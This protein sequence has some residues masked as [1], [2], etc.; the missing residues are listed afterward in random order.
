MTRTVAR[1]LHMMPIGQPV[2]GYRRQGDEASF[3]GATVVRM[4][5]FTGVHP[6][7]ATLLFA[8]DL[9]HST[10]SVRRGEL[11]RVN[12]GVYARRDEWARLAPWE[13]YAERVRAHVMWHPDDTLCLE[14]AAALSGLP[15]I[16]GDHDIHVLASHSASARRAVGV[17]VHVGDPADR[18]MIELDGVRLTSVADTCIDIA[19]AR[20]EAV[21]LAVADAT[22]RREP[23]LRSVDLV[24]MNED[25]ASSRGRRRARWGLQRANG[26]AESALESLS[27]ACIE[28]QGFPAPELQ[29]WFGASEDTG[30]RVDHWWPSQS[31]A[32]E[33]DGHLKYDGRFGDPLTALRAQE[34]RD[35]RLRD[36]G[37]RT[38]VHW[39]WTDVVDTHALR[40]ILHGAGL[41]IVTTPDEGRLA[42]MRRLLRSSSRETA[43]T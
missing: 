16:G 43:S 18:R 19:R 24:A 12:R 7:A 35:R 37:A 21:A 41:P 34:Q 6:P 38:V 14:S 11:L 27:R 10:R 2:H 5:I 26:D 17:R 25:R 42:S 29:T 4:S 23:S 33:A 40:A 22:L 13:R 1:L 8:R 9:V 30:D 31:V 20:H 3:R 28:W 36:A 32:G 39:T 15:V